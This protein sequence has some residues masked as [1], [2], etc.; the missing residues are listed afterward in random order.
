MDDDVKRELD[1][2]W[3]C[4]QAMNDKLD[5][6]MEQLTENRIRVAMTSAVLGFLGGA[7][8]VITAII[9]KVIR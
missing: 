2:L 7:V 4:Q 3:E 1:R 5:R 8:P 6:I 9:L